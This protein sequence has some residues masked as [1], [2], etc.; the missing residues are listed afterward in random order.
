MISNFDSN[1]INNPA[2]KYLMLTDEER[3]N[4]PEPS[5]EE[6]RSSAE[7]GGLDA[8]MN[9]GLKIQYTGDAIMCEKQRKKCIEFF[10]GYWEMK[11]KEKGEKI[12]DMKVKITG[13]VMKKILFDS[14]NEIDK[15]NF[16]IKSDTVERL[17]QFH[18]P[19]F[20]N[21]MF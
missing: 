14:F 1:D 7:R 13:E 19:Q 21:S 11:C 8:D 2:I 20:R 15:S 18:E 6:I 16:A 17:L 3:K 9:M 10:D 5:P 4:A 12:K